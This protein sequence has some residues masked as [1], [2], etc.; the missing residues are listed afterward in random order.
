MNLID[1]IGRRLRSRRRARHA[2]E[3]RE[4]RLTADLSWLTEPH[5]EDKAPV[6]ESIE[7]REDPHKE[8]ADLDAP[9]PPPVPKRIGEDATATST[10]LT[11][12]WDAAVTALL[13]FSGQV[14]WQIAEWRFA[15]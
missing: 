7:G 4:D 10:V 8:L 13:R 14:R 1:A 15:W 5:T 12:D 3:Q 11:D 2:K 9:E 6:V